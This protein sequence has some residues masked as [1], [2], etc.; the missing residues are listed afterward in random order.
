MQ[1]IK[2][3][4]ARANIL[5]SS[6]ITSTDPETRPIAHIKAITKFTQQAFTS[7]SKAVF[8]EHWNICN[9]Q[10]LSSNRVALDIITTLQ[11]GT[12]AIIQTEGCVFKLES[13]NLSSLLNHMRT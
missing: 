12:C 7:N 10:N 5:S 9:E 3:G 1:D 4:Y 2:E 6:D 8:T 11:G 13:A